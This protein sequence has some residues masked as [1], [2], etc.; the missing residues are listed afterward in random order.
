M[1]PTSQKFHYVFSLRE[2]SRCFQGLL[3]ASRESATVSEKALIRLWQHEG[4]LVFG[5]RL[6]STEDKQ[7]FCD[8]QAVAAEGLVTKSAGLT[9]NGP[10]S[11]ATGGKE[12]KRCVDAGGVYATASTTAPALRSLGTQRKTSHSLRGLPP[13]STS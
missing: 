6:V 2:L 11:N 12:K 5:D 4:E 8:E 3:R 13:R 10:A 1:P 9:G 7:R